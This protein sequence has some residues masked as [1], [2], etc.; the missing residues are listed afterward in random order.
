MKK[1]ISILVAFA[2]MASLCVAMAFAEGEKTTTAPISKTLTVPDGTAIPE[3]AE[4]T[5]TFTDYKVNGAAPEAT[6]PTIDTKTLDLTTGTKTDNDTVD[7]YSYTIADVLAG[8]EFKRPG[9]Y[10][11]TVQEATYVIDDANPATTD[12]PGKDTTVYK[13]VVKVIY[14]QNGNLVI[15]EVIIKE[16]TDDPDNPGTTQWNEKDGLAFANTYYTT[17]GNDTVEPGDPDDPDDPDVP[18]DPTKD[19][20]GLSVEKVVTGTYGD[21]NHQF[22]IK[23][24]LSLPQIDGADTAEA[25]IRRASGDIEA[26]TI[27]NGENTVALASGDKLVFTKIAE[28]AKYQVIETDALKGTADNQYTATYSGDTATENAQVAIVKAGNSET[29]TNVANQDSITPTGIL[30]NNLPYI[31]LALVAIGGLVAYVIVRRRQDD[32]A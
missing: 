28:G 6:D 11:W 14:D 13:M 12:V 17:T 24:T 15:D 5:F 25:V 20:A 7:V 22:N 30:I 4:A 18:G 10:E 2:M 9:V 1:L 16:G 23:V 19:N 27:Q 3:G 31:A 21:K 32:E 8:K 29:V 26:V